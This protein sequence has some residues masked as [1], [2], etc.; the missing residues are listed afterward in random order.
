MAQT[1][2]GQILDFSVVIFRPILAKLIKNVIA[3]C[4]LGPIFQ[5][6]SP[7]GE[8]GRVSLTYSIKFFSAKRSGRL[9]PAAA[10]GYTIVYGF[11][12]PGGP[13]IGRLIS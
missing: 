1:F 8:L 11:R 12:S 3:S 7:R 13:G 9:A 6:N 5:K 4:V 10:E 2:Q